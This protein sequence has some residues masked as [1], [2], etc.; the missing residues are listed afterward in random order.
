MGNVFKS[1]QR[2]YYATMTIKFIDDNG[3]ER[4]EEHRS[5]DSDNPIKATIEVES[6]RPIAAYGIQV[7]LVRIEKT[8]YIDDDNDLR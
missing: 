4:A 8:R 3:N 2:L 7:S 1:K 6:D 5:Y